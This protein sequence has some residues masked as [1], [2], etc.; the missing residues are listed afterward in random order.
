MA[1][2]TEEMALVREYAATRSQQAFAELVRRYVDLIYSSAKRQAGGDAHLAEDV[3][4]AVFIVLAQK[5]S[6]VPP[7]R[8]L[9]AWLLKVTG[10]CAANARRRKG[11]AELHE[12]RAAQ[13]ARND[14]LQA[15]A[16][17]AKADWYELAPL[18][19]QGLA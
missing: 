19:D 13:M 16:G 12:R 8:P 9:S 18:L 7:D 11:R 4:Q 6:S 10:Y 2:M 1:Q 14:H 15:E 17:Q 3:T 5:A